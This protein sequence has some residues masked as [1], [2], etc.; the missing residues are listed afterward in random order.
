MDLPFWLNYTMINEISKDFFDAYRNNESDGSE[1][2][3]SVQSMPV[4]QALHDAL[5][6]KPPPQFCDGGWYARCDSNARPSESESDTLSNWATGTYSAHLLYRFP[7]AFA[8]G[9]ERK[10]KIKIEILQKKM[11]TFVPGGDNINKLSP[12]RWTAGRT[13]KIEQHSLEIDWEINGESL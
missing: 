7:V 3:I 9:K 13:L 4:A 11:L 5:K 1:G 2:M 12:T 6:R 8:R 10:I